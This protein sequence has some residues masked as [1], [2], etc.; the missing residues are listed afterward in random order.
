M[1]FNVTRVGLCFKELNMSKKIFRSIVSLRRKI[2][3][4]LNVRN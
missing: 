1:D 2:F 4:T 3:S